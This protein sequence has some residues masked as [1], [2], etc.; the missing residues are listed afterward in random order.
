MKYFVLAL[1]ILFSSVFAKTALKRNEFDKDGKNSPLI[2]LMIQQLNALGARMEKLRDIAHEGQKDMISMK[3]DMANLKSKYGNFVI[4]KNDQS[5]DEINS[6]VIAVANKK[7]IDHLTAKLDKFDTVANKNKIDHLEA[8]LDKFD[9]SKLDKQIN[10]VL[11]QIRRFNIKHGNIGGGDTYV[12]WGRTTCPSTNGT[13]FV[14]SGY[15]GGGYYAAH[16]AP[17]EPDVPC[18]VCHVE[19]GTTI[20]IPGKTTCNKGWKLEYAGN[21]AAGAAGHAAAS[22]YLCVDMDPEYIHH[23]GHD[24]IGKLLY[25][26]VGQ[27]GSLPCPPYRHG[28]PLTCAVCSK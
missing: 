28:Y 13:T 27:C 18:S 9:N 17:A 7:K 22:T 14:Y 26:V 3:R 21:L 25:E 16:G 6:K 5:L 8:K 15:T 20:M 11:S 19:F 10:Q 1:C 4:D 23:G 2:W 12:R 24:Y